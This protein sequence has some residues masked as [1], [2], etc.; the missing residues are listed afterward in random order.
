MT[1]SRTSLVCHRLYGVRTHVLLLIVCD[2]LYSWEVLLRRVKVVDRNLVHCD[3]HYR[4]MAAV[5]VVSMEVWLADLW[6]ATAATAN[7][8]DA[9]AMFLFHLFTRLEYGRQQTLILHERTIMVV[10]TDV[11]Y[12][13]CLTARDIVLKITVECLVLTVIYF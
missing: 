9:T 13:T 8:D 11:T 1:L 7:T 5:I 2:F 4:T 10:F 12:A 3:V 6:S